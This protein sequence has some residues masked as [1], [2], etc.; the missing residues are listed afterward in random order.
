M[1]QNRVIDEYEGELELAQEPGYVSRYEDDYDDVFVAD[2][3]E[4]ATA[5]KPKETRKTEIQ[6]SEP[7]LKA[8]HTAAPS[9]EPREAATKHS[10]SQKQRD[11]FGAGILD[12]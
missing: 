6:P 8:P 11:G 4:P 2:Y 9:N 12:D 1:F 3:D 10:Q 7:G 5:P